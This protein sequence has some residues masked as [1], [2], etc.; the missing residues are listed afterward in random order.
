[1]F[2]SPYQALY[3]IPSNFTT[4]PD[5]QLGI[6]TYFPYQPSDLDEFFQLYTDIPPG[7]RP[8]EISIDGAPTSSPNYVTEEPSIDI[9]AAFP[10]VY[11]QNITWFGDQQIDSDV[12]E[13]LDAVDGVSPNDRAEKVIKVR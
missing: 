12:D 10:I 3:N 6:V 8:L 1:M 5:N 9:D 2:C 4:E 11:P 7:T 13:F